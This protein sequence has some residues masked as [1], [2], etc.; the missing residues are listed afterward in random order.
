MMATS[1]N[2]EVPISPSHH[3]SWVWYVKMKE[4]R[5]PSVAVARHSVS[6]VVGL[7]LILSVCF[8]Y[9]NPVSE[10]IRLGELFSQSSCV[11]KHKLFSP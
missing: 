1:S 5:G 10:K 2:L 4:K 3:R 7:C 9:C 11:G 8:H 6:V